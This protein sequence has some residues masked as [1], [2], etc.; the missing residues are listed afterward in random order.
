MNLITTSNIAQMTG[1]KPSNVSNSYRRGLLPKPD[2]TVNNH[3]PL[4]LPETIKDYIEL[5]SK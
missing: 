2:F 3:T 4:W 5:T 1:R